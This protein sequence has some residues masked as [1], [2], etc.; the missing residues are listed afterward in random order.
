VAGYDR[1]GRSLVRKRSGKVIQ[2][3]KR[4]GKILGNMLRYGLGS[5]LGKASGNTLGY[6]SGK[7]LG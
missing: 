1:V 5:D 3:G 4:S 7:Q 2:P 6:D